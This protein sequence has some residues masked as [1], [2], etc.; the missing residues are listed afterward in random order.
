M[1]DDPIQNVTYRPVSENLRKAIEK[2]LEAEFGSQSAPGGPAPG[3]PPPPPPRIA[4][5]HVKFG[6]GVAHQIDQISLIASNEP[7]LLKPIK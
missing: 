3:T 1:A 6:F 7:S 4:T 5:T 2:A